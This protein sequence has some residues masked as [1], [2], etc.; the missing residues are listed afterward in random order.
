VLGA[1][2]VAPTARRGTG[3]QVFRPMTD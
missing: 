3:P 2:N 1:H